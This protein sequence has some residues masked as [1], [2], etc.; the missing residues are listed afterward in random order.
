M[1]SIY[2]HTLAPHGSGSAELTWLLCSLAPEPTRLRLCGLH[3]IALPWTEPD[4]SGPHAQAGL[5]PVE[6]HSCF[7]C[8]LQHQR[9][10]ISTRTEG[11]WCPLVSSTTNMPRGHSHLPAFSP[12]WFQLLTALS[13]ASPASKQ[14]VHCGRTVD[15][16]PRSITMV[17]LRPMGIVTVLVTCCFGV[18]LLL[19]FLP[20]KPYSWA[21]V[22]SAYY[23]HS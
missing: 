3:D 22:L 1:P 19:L 10:F 13:L 16:Y 11:V 12:T 8:L 17:L 6:V 23:I 4:S 14:C 18:A 7:L 2:N 20:D 15:H 9:P 5:S 21:Y